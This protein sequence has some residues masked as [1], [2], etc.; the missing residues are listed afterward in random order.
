MESVVRVKRDL[1]RR[2]IVGVDT[3]LIVRRGGER[4][5]R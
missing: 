1:Q 3:V 5:L 4:N 2:P